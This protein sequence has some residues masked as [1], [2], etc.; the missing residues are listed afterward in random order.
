MSL[1]WKLVIAYL[2][3]TVAGIA[4]EILRVPF[5]LRIAGFYAVVILVAALWLRARHR[6][7]APLRERADQLR[8]T[9]ALVIPVLIDP[10]SAPVGAASDERRR[11]SALVIGTSHGLEIR[12]S[13]ES[14][15]LAAAWADVSDVRFGQSS[16]WTPNI[17]LE[18]DRDE[19]QQEW[20]LNPINSFG[21]RRP[22]DPVFEAINSLERL[23]IP[24][25]DAPVPVEPT[26]P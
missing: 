18:I 9:G 12:L 8:A 14:T 7:L 15:L 10:V 5:G 1:V 24:A 17:T 20:W 26:E 23:R 16:R 22:S 25:K 13:D 3:L 21:F 6:K 19:G 4:S 2:L 11:M